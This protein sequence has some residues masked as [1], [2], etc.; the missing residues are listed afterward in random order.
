MKVAETT[1]KEWFISEPIQNPTKII[2]QKQSTDS[3]KEEVHLDD[4]DDKPKDDDK[5]VDENTVQPELS[6]IEDVSQVFEKLK[7]DKENDFA[8]YEDTPIDSYEKA[9]EF[10]QLNVNDKLSKELERIDQT[11]YNTKPEAFQRV[12]QLAE[13]A[14]D[15]FSKVA[16]LIQKEKFLQDIENLDASDLE[17]AETI[18]TEHMKLR[19]EPK[20]VI[21]EE[22]KD[23]KERDKLV[24]R[25]KKYQPSL[26]ESQKKINE[27]IIEKEKADLISFYSAIENNNKEVVSFLS[28]PKIAGMDLKIEDKN[29]IYQSLVYNPEIKG[30]GINKLVEDLHRE[31]KFELLAK[32]TLLAQDEDK[33][34][35]IYTNRIKSKV[36][37]DYQKKIRYASEQTESQDDVR[38]K[39]VV[40]TKAKDVDSK[41]FNPWK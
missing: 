30:F 19:G 38:Q 13:M 33:F 28:N 29:A 9:V 41:D 12:A 17:N 39:Q 14:G 22:I 21:L 18:V 2:D 1:E 16:D 36:A 5:V 8:W 34:E 4:N 3:T 32:I 26:I 11:W 25:A 10:I 27:A 6:L 40:Q 35:Q 7:S 31:K 24:E 37:K 20:D 23:L 15:D